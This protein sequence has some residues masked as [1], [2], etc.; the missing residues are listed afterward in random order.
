LF[1]DH[2][3]TISNWTRALEYRGRDT[4]SELSDYVG[5]EFLRQMIPQRKPNEAGVLA[6][7]DRS[8]GKVGNLKTGEV[9]DLTE[10]PLASD[11]T[12]LP[13][14]EIAKLWKALRDGTLEPQ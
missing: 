7:L 6:E 1:S 2:A 11:E 14:A 9:R 12:F 4:M 13:N 8:K 10:S 3:A 5:K